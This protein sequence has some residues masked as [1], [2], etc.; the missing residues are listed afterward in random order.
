VSA[1]GHPRCRACGEPATTRFGSQHRSV[2]GRG[3]TEFVYH[4]CPRCALTFVEPV[5][6]DS[7]Y[8]DAYYA[9]RGVDPSVNY[10]AEYEGYA[11]TDRRHEFSD[12]LRLAAEHLR[13]SGTAQAADDVA[14]LDFGCGAGGLLKFLR[15]SGRLEPGGRP[16]RAAGADVG[17]YARRLAEVDGFEIHAPDALQ[18][19]PDAQFDVISAIEVVEHLEHPSPVIGLLA[20]LLRPGGLLLLT[21]GNLSSPM[22]RLQGLRFRYCL[23]EIHVSLFAPRTL[24]HLYRIHGLTPVRVRYK[25]ALTFKILKTA[26]S[27]S[28]RRLL[29]FALRV[30]GF[31]RA[32]DLL[33]GTSAMPCAIKGPG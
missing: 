15:D 12:L 28:R 22:A 19:L 30:P 25:G 9:G 27:P 14:W 17:S 33:Y 23:P 13:H 20:R 8:D 11:K 7:I 6:P 4:R 32:V 1:P 29:G 31:R 16:V 2:A 10:Q 18:R 5:L 3:P 26:G 21:T 24:S